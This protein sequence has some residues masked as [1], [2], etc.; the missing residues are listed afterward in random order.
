MK[1]ILII[2]LVLIIVLFLYKSFPKGKSSNEISLNDLEKIL[3]SVNK[4]KIASVSKW[5]IY[6][7]YFNVEGEITNVSS[8]DKIVLVLKSMNNEVEYPLNI[9]KTQDTIS[10]KT[11]K[12]IN[13]GINLEKMAINKYILLLK[14]IDN[15]NTNYY[16]LTNNTDYENLDYWTISK[17]DKH[18]NI[19]IDFKKN[20]SYEFMEMKVEAKELP[21]DVYDIVLD[22][23]HGGVDSGAYNGSELEKNYNLSYA[24]ALKETLEN[25]GLRVK[26]TRE[27]DVLIK[28]YGYASRTGIPYEAKAKLMLS[29][30]LNSGIGDIGHGG[31]EV[32]IAN[33]DKH[34]FAKLIADNIVSK[35]TSEYSKNGNN[36][37]LDGVYMRTYK[38]NDILAI[39]KEAK[40][41]SWVPYEKMDY[42]TTYYYFIREPGGIITTALTDGRNPKYDKNPYYLS[43]H[44]V[45]AYLI[46]LGYI[47]NN[48]NLKQIKEERANYVK[49]IADSIK[50][51]I[52]N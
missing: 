38:K 42:N 32:Y 5:T 4:D 22:P 3:S 1:K 12:Y 15:N 26:L 28:N 6:G 14:V 17:N 40:E 16:N 47:S 36:R 44:G 33:G 18:N 21:S 7:K 37:I 23:G 20:E 52:E 50:S 10:F 25:M 8:Y 34:D 49:A 30:H 13:E 19:I 9:T 11:N 27:D 45:E 51:Y 29:L 35:T 43:N 2:C 41:N 48:Y 46:E 31:V 39:N 24:K